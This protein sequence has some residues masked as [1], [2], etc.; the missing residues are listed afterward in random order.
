MFDASGFPFTGI[1]VQVLEDSIAWNVQSLGILLIP[2]SAIIGFATWASVVGFARQRR[3]EREAYYRGEVNKKLVEEGKLSVPQ[4]I[5]AREEEMH[6]QWL[7]RREAFKGA[8][9]VLAALGLAIVAAMGAADNDEAMGAGFVPMFLGGA[10]L[11]Y[12]TGLYP[13]W[14]TVRGKRLANGDP[15]KETPIL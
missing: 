4:L 9:I 6:R 12:G 13:A 5:A 14:E 10:L 7:K 2:V 15:D 8:G 1:A 11:A 3:L